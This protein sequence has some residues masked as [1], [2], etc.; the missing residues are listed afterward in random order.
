MKAAFGHDSKSTSQ[1][2]DHT[3]MNS[4]FT[5]CAVIH[6]AR[7][8]YRRVCISL[9]LIAVQFNLN[10]LSLGK[11]SLIIRLTAHASK[12][13][14]LDSVLIVSIQCGHKDGNEDL[15]VA[16]FIKRYLPGGESNPAFARP[17]C[18]D[19]RVY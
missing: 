14:S 19:R 4:A 17:A 16:K 2:C 8:S 5:P 13:T 11:S 12:S 7:E 9:T 15:K 3:L 10:V 6:N 1:P 18:G